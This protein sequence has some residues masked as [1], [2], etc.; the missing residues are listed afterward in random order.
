MTLVYRKET[1]DGREIWY[2]WKNNVT[3][4]IFYIDWQLNEN[5]MVRTSEEVNRVM[6]KAGI[7]HRFGPKE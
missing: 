7:S 4:D 5:A 3:G 6:K 2:T 1:G